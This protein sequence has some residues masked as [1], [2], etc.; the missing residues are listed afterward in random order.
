MNQPRSES[1]EDKTTRVLESI[2]IKINDL[3]KSY[4]G[5]SM[6]MRNMKE[7]VTENLADVKVKIRDNSNALDKL[8]D[9]HEKKIEALSKSHA[10]KISKLEQNQNK[11]LGAIVFMGTLAALAAKLL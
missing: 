10:L 1:F 7:S 8:E 2:L 5:L 9:R 4:T 3:D 6:E 11:I